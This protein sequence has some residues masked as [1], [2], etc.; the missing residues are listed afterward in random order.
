MKAD[1]R[2]PLYKILEQMELCIESFSLCKMT[3]QSDYTNPEKS[4]LPRF[5]TLDIPRC[6]EKQESCGLVQRRPGD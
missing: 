4:W 5:G 1:D 3:Q 6:N 2:Y